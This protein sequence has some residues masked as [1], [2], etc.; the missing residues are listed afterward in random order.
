[1]KSWKSEDDVAD[2]G[3]NYLSICTGVMLTNKEVPAFAAFLQ[4][5]L[6]VAKELDTTL[7]YTAEF[8]PAEMETFAAMIVDNDKGKIVPRYYR[9]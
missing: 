4:A 2:V 5:M 1:M 9:Y 7:D 8:T 3:E 6:D